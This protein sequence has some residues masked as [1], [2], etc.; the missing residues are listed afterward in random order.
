MFTTFKRFKHSCSMC[1]S[2]VSHLPTKVTVKDREE[3]YLGILH[4]SG[5]KLFCTACNIVVDHKHKSYIDKHFTTSKHNYRTAELKAGRQT[6]RSAPKNTTLYA[7]IEASDNLTTHMHPTL[8]VT[9]LFYCVL[10]GY[11]IAWKGIRATCE[12]IFCFKSEF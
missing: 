2:N 10:V 12:F 8:R 1:A 9:L 7:P 6:T 11:S 4:E 3:Q 5:G